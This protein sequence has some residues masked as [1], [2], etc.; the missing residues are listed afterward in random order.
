MDKKAVTEKDIGKL[1]EFWNNDLIGI[2][3]LYLYDFLDKVYGDSVF[4]PKSIQK[5]FDNCR[6]LTCERL[7]EINGNE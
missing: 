6:V 3:S 2:P 7:Q 4:I 1:C 5:P